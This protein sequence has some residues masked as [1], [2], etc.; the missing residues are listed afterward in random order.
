MLGELDF[1]V[2][3]WRPRHGRIQDAFVRSIDP[4]ISLFLRSGGVRSGEAEFAMRQITGRA[5]NDVL[6]SFHLAIHGYLNQAYNSLR[7]V[8][9]GL[10]LR[11]L[12]TAETH[13]AAEWVNSDK[14]YRDFAPGA[15]RQRLGR[16]SYNELHGLFSERAH[17]RFESAHLTSVMR[18]N[19][20]DGRPTAVVRLGPFMIDDH[21]A[22]ME[23][24]LY[25]FDV[26]GQLTV[27]SAGLVDMAPR[28]NPHD[29]LLAVQTM[30]G[31][32]VEGGELIQQ[33]LEAMGA[34]G[35]EPV[36][37]RHRRVL[38][39]VSSALGQR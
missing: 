18:S 39:D 8:I 34:S 26:T 1:P 20:E 9:E 24:L 2:S 27:E 36:I 38:A 13:A 11:E 23:A 7:M 4:M 37:D 12:I 14:P 31:A 30:A 33:E 29:L 17:P 16:A 25:V 6:V 22:V 5:I 19:R 28:L 10:E 3:G 32:V 15:V 21:P 35:A